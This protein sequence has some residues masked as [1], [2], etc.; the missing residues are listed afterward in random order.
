MPK[1]ILA[2][3]SYG[4]NLSICHRSLLSLMKPNQT[5][6]ADKYVLTIYKDDIDNLSKNPTLMKLVLENKLEIIIAPVDLKNNNKYYWVMQKYDQDPIIL[7]DDDHEYKDY[8]IERLYESYLKNPKC[9]S[10]LGCRIVYEGKRFAVD[11]FHCSDRSKFSLYEIGVPRNDLIP[12]GAW[13]SLY[14]PSYMFK[15]D[16]NVVFNYIRKF[17]ELQKHDDLVLYQIMKRNNINIVP[18]AQT[19]NNKSFNLDFGIEP[20]SYLFNMFGMHPNSII[21]HD[22][23]DLIF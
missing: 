1:L 11:T 20:V 15:S 3:T 10:S 2:F 13:G 9:V 7:V 21:C 19:T 17:Y 12:E 5:K 14:P 22:I 18:L 23:L 6:E 4:R 16:L 8:V